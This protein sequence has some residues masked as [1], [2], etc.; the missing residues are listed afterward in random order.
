M[1]VWQNQLHMYGFSDVVNLLSSAPGTALLFWCGA[2]D[3]ESRETWVTIKE[4]KD[5]N[6]ESK[7]ARFH[8]RMH[9]YPTYK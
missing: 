8:Q 3:Y 4:L 9:F 5:Q 7:I 1:F 2:L 6:N